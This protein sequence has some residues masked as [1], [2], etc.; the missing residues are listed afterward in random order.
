[1][2]G[3]ATAGPFPISPLLGLKLPT[4][5]RH[6]RNEFSRSR[7]CLSCAARLRCREAK[8]AAFRP[9]TNSVPQKIDDVIQIAIG[10]CDSDL[11]TLPR[12]V[13]TEDYDRIS[14]TLVRYKL[15]AFDNPMRAKHCPMFDPI[16]GKRGASDIGLECQPDD[17]TGK[18]NGD[19][20]LEASPSNIDIKCYLAY[21]RA[22]R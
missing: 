12:R 8:L 3:P 6:V 10:S 18:S 16:R 2:E 9:D 14:S 7:T 20:G 17:R 1:M 13:L 5:R 4:C 19:P 22:D 21:R 11:D 15:A